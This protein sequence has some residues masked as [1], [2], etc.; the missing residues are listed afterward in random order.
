MV[1][2][3]RQKDLEE[4]ATAFYE[5]LTIVNIEYGGIGLDPKRP[6]GSSFIEADILGIIGWDEE[7][8]DDGYCTREQ[9]D[10]ARSLYHDHLIPYL[11]D[12][13]LSD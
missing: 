12:K 2:R 11:R 9:R 13:H 8:G 7:G 10:Y 6:F 1:Q 4:L 5:N 3:D